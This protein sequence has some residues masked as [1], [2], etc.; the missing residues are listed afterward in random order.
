MRSGHIT[1]L[2]ESAT[3][4]YQFHLELPN[5]SEASNGDRVAITGEGEFSIHPK[6]AEGTG[7]F[8]HRNA[9]GTLVGAGTWTATEL[10]EYQSYGCGVVHNFPTPGATTPL[11]SN[12]CGG[13]AKMRI[14]ATPNGTSLKIDAILT[15][16]CIIG[17]NPPNSHDDPSGEGITLVV[18]GIINFNK[19]VQGMNVFIQES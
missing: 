3:H 11:P 18:P 7:T 5:V 13:A 17:P 9:S 2:A 14:V 10:L 4:T 6:A 12:F 15:I 16:F 1:P 8:T 19:I